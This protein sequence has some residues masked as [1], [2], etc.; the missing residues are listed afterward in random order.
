MVRQAL[1]SEGLTLFEGTKVVSVARD[2]N[3]I[4][5]TVTET[6]DGPEK[7][8]KG[9]HLLIAAGRK[10]NV[11]GLGLDKAGIEYGP[12]GISVDARLRTSNKKI[13]AIGD[14]TGGYQFTHMAG[15]QAGIV[16]RNALFRLPAKLD[17]SA[18]PWVTYTDPELAQVGLTEQMARERF[19]DKVKLLSWSFQEND[20]ARAEGRSEGFVKAMVDGR[21]RI[22]GATIVGAHAGE[23]LQSW[24]LAMSAGLKIGAMAK[25]IAPYPTRGEINK[26]VAGSYFTSALFSA[27]TKKLVR[28]LQFLP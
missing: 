23:L 3:A 20:R 1:L 10:A 21:G 13:F 7:T 2:G 19:G 17:T 8:I 15:Y 24:S 4:A 22:L 14:V 12:R 9:T 28:A 25:F 6:P 5:V 18:V 26:R 16:I 27:K 11:D